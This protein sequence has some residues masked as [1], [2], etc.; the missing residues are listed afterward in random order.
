MKNGSMD[1]AVYTTEIQRIIRC[2]YEQV[3]TK[4]FDNLEEI[5]IFLETIYQNWRHTVIT[6]NLKR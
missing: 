3:Y 5:G 1:S 2:L 4:H 6:E